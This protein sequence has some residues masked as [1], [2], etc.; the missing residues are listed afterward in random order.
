MQKPF[1]DAAFALE[2]NE[3]S[4]LERDE[5]RMGSLPGRTW[6]GADR[7]ASPIYFSAMNGHLEGKT[8]NT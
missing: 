2:V 8:K 3:L 7:M 1:E 6:K 4:L 5:L